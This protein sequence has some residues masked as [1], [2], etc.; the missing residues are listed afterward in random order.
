MAVGPGINLICYTWLFL[1]D[2]AARNIMM[3]M[4]KVCKV[5]Y[6]FVCFLSRFL[7]SSNSMDCIHCS[8]IVSDQV[9]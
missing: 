7:G 9:Q 2:L 3:D 5:S 4:Q 1:Q 6:D 8:I